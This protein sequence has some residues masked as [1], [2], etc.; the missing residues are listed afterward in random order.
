VITIQG[1]CDNPSGLSSN[2]ADC[3]TVVTRAD[4]EKLTGPNVPAAQK[5][6][7]ADQY[8]KA[9][10]IEQKAHE[11]GLD[12]TP[13]FEQQLRIVRLKIL[14]SLEAQKL[15]KDAGNVPD[16]E[17]EDYYR[18]HA[19]DYKT[20][21]FERLYVPK[22]K[23]VDPSTQKPNDPDAEKKRAASEAEMKEEADKLRARA[24]AGED[25]TK[26][27]QEAYDFAGLKQKATSPRQENVR[28][29]G[30]PPADASIFDLKSGEVSQVFNDPT[31]LMVYKIEETKDLPLE[32]ARAEISRALQAEKFKS[33]MDALQNS[34]K[35]TLDENYF[36]TPAPPTLK[37]PG[38]A[39]TAQAPPPGKK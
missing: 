8:A 35:I 31:G 33:S 30:V 17:T 34:S 18:Q 36:A 32:N 7:V 15:Q 3:K 37:K 11:Q 2:P 25:F 23:F 38:E 29:T 39:P 5:K 24:A 21:S 14:V 10:V 20:I 22:Q 19:A 1:L 6:S 28:R 12:R 27:Q 26:L 9:L 13:E 16:N 4:F